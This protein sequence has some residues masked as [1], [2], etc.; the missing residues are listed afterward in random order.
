MLTMKTLT[1]LFMMMIFLF[2]SPAD[3][4]IVDRTTDRAKSKTNNRIDNRIDRGIDK[5]LDGIE[6]AFKRKNKDKKKDKSSDDDT[7][8]AS[9]SEDEMSEEEANAM[10]MRALGGMGGGST[11]DLPSE[12][13]FDHRV[14]MVITTFDKKGKQDAVQN[15]QV[16]FSDKK[17][18]MGVSVQVEGTNSVSVIDMEAMLMVMLMDMGSNKMAMT[19][20]LN[21]EWLEENDDESITAMESFKKTGRTKTILGYKCDEY[22]MT[23]DEGTTEFWITREDDLDI[24]RAFG[25]MSAS[26]PDNKKGKGNSLPAGHPG[27]MTMLTT[28]VSNDGE[29]M[30]MEVTDVKKNSPLSIQTAGYSQMSFPGTK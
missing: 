30:I 14:D 6:N 10:V 9:A 20:D 11:V 18:Y 12:Y 3:G 26:S 28:M 27:G 7:K 17:P 2:A 21:S 15:M 16:L 29:K 19:I 4:Q 13:A 8:A 22:V 24:Y 23:D 25:A 5:G 1:A